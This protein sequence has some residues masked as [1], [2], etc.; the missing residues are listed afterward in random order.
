ML[1]I[2]TATVPWSSLSP[3]VLGKCLTYPRLSHDPAPSLVNH[4]VPKLFC[5]LT[6]SPDN[7]TPSLLVS[8]QTSIPPPFPSLLSGRDPPFYFTERAEETRREHLPAPTTSSAVPSQ[9]PA[10]Q[11]FFLFW[12]MNCSSAN[13]QVS[14]ETKSHSS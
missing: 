14:R 11:P 13:R 7:L 2:D 9:W 12:W 5:A 10:T 3:T 6:L 1:L 8:P 4:L